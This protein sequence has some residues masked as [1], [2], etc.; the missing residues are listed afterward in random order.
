MRRLPTGLVVLAF[1][2][3]VLP[4]AARAAPEV[5]FEARFAPIAGYRDTGNHLGAGAILDAAYKISGTEYGGFPP[6]LIGLT[7]YV[8]PGMKT[9]ARRFKACA[10]RVIVN[11]KEPGSCPK[12]SEGGVGRVKGIVTFHDERVAEEA[13]LRSFFT[14]GLGL[15]FLAI[16]HTPVSL[17]APW[18][19]EFGDFSGGG[20]FGGDLIAHAPLVETSP[21]AFDMSVEEIEFAIGTARHIRTRVDPRRFGSVYYLTVTKRCP[22]GGF[23]FKSELTFAGVHGLP[24]QTVTALYFAPCPRR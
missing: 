19:A 20:G 16:G 10:K 23:P 22:R 6:P 5:E 17:K 9:R 8:P 18:A 1:I 21:G 11:R 13:T 7:L 3:L 12:G 15:S 4:P 2:A 24:Q 14:P